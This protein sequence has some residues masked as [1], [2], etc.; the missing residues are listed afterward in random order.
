MLKKKTIKLAMAAL[1]HRLKEIRGNINYPYTKEIALI[2]YRFAETACQNAINE[3]Q[4]ELDANS[5]D[6]F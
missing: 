3:L 6:S 1:K 5:P 4:A 2:R